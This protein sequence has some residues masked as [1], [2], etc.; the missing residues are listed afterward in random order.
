M[1]DL[2]TIS[3]PQVVQM[4]VILLDLFT[5]NYVITS[6]IS[7][8]TSH[9]IKFHGNSAAMG[10]FHCSA[11]NYMARGKLWALVVYIFCVLFWRSVL[12]HGLVGFRG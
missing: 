2:R 10:K 8:I 6:A 3:R 12:W 11:R 9:F 5:L 1:N 7:F 4:E